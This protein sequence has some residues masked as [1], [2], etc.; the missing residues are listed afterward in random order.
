MLKFS[1]RV[2]G[3][4]KGNKQDGDYIK[5]VLE[6][7]RFLKDKK[8]WAFILASNALPLVWVYFTKTKA[9]NQKIFEK[10]RVKALWRQYLAEN[11]F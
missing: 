1:R 5:E 2:V 9:G 4:L 7:R 3:G 10:S 8:F 6:Q 11:T